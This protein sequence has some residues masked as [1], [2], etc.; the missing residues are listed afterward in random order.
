M[1]DL[2]TKVAKYQQVKNRISRWCYFEPYDVDSF[3]E[4][5]GALSP[6]FA[7]L[8]GRKR[9]HRDQVELLHEECEGLIGKAIP[10]L[11]RF[12]SLAQ[13]LPENEI[14]TDF[15]RAIITDVRQGEILAERAQKNWERA[16]KV[17]A[18]QVSH[19]NGVPSRTSSP[20]KER[21]RHATT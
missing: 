11:T 21:G 3:W 15:L 1:D 20:K 17:T 8:D 7:G 6:H 19:D 12:A 18:E 10:F 9:D 2:P 16:P 5:L 4:L 13:T 14:G